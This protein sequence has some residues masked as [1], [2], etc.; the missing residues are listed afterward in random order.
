[1]D[2]RG[3]D[4]PQDDVKLPEDRVEDLEPTDSSPRVSPEALLASSSTRTSR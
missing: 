4:Q 3:Q 1:M 2:E